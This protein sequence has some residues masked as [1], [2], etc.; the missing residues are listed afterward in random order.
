MIAQ[1]GNTTRR[2]TVIA[3]ALALVLTGVALT[4]AVQAQAPKQPSATQPTTAPNDA[5]LKALWKYDV[6]RQLLAKKS[7]TP[8]EHEAALRDLREEIVKKELVLLPGGQPTNQVDVERAIK[9]AQQNLSAVVLERRQMA[10]AA[11]QPAG[12]ATDENPDDALARRLLERRLPEVRFEAIAFSDVVD[13]LRDVTSANIFVNWRAL[14]AAGIDRSAPVTTRLRD[15]RFRDA[16]D[17]IL[18]DLGGGTVSLGHV[19]D[20]GTITISTDGSDLLVNTF[21]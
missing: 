12:G 6:A 1:F 3:A 18:A 19:V 2:W 13:F 11:A 10:D 16:L 4:D 17:K 21:R 14:E 15:V 9:E 7:I 5:V 20:R 8:Q